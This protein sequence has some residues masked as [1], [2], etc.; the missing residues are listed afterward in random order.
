[1]MI[2]RFFEATLASSVH[3]GR[4]LALYGPRR[5]GKT[6]LLKQYV[7]TLGHVGRCLFTTGEDMNLQQVLSSQSVET[8]KAFFGG[9]DLIVID[10]AQAVQ[11][12]GRGLKLLVDWLPKA[13][14]IASGASSFQIADQIGEPLTGRKKTLTLYPISAAELVLHEG[15][16]TV[17]GRLNDLL[18]YGMYP[19]IVAAGSSAER[20]ELLTEL[21]NDYLFR[22]IIAFE[23][24]KNSDKIKKLVSLISFQAGKEVSLSEL[25]TGIGMSRQVVERHLDLL[26]KSFVIFR[27]GGFSRNLRSEITKSVR[28]YFY[29]NG[30][31]NAVQNNF[32]PVE[33][34]PDVGAL[35][36]NWL[37]AER[38]KRNGYGGHFV[39]SYFWRT[40]AQQEI[41]L[42][43]E[44]DGKL[45]A[46][47]FKW[48]GKSPK[49]P[50]SWRDA[51][52]EADYA[53][54]NRD[55]FW[56]FVI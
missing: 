11:N 55:N 29:D 10:E 36:E 50:K 56:D 33:M 30:I 5:V 12:L 26:E 20:R 1:M 17:S 32:S 8:I 47:E 45:N 25:A 49:A 48:G 44:S 42:V 31:L 37:V 46:F 27:V 4:V 51:Y 52:P 18:V 19:E 14:V 22:D 38:I 23:G 7:S 21:R 53:V 35:W 40:Y 15:R 9:Y 39:S 34:R 6:T 3:P 16:L 41:D 24:I 54:I 13:K 2:P 28:Y 43:E